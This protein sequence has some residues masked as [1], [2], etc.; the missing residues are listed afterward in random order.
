MYKKTANCQNCDKF[1]K[2]GIVLMYKPLRI[3]KNSPHVP[4]DM[5]RFR[6]RSVVDL[7][8]VRY[9]ASRIRHLYG[10]GSGSGS[11]PEK[12]RIF[13]FFSIVLLAVCTD[14]RL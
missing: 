3:Q 2:S 12:V 4:F 9:W 6:G 1:Q 11:R 14:I 7:G 10:S 8:S 5:N 13:F